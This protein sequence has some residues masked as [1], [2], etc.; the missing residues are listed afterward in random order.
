MP[1]KYKVQLT[2]NSLAFV[3]YTRQLIV[4][5]FEQKRPHHLRPKYSVTVEMRKRRGIKSGKETEAEKGHT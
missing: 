2:V 4:L 3:L 1:I 5:D